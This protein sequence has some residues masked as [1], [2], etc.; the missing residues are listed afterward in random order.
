MKDS[1]SPGLNV[2]YKEHTGVIRFVGEN[3]ITVC[4]QH[5]HSKVNDVCIIVYPNEYNL[6]H[7]IKESEK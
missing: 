7:L 5:G 3:Y 1:F 6:V 4:I 2:Y